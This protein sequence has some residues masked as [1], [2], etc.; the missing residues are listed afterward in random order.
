MGVTD[1]LWSVGK[2]FVPI[3]LKSLIVLISHQV[4]VRFKVAHHTYSLF[5][6]D[7]YT[8]RTVGWREDNFPVY[9]QFIQKRL[10]L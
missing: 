9:P 1:H 8:V 6:N 4:F 10:T 3:F 7:R 2:D 5:L